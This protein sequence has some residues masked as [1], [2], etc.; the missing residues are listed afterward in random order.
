MRHRFVTFASAVLTLIVAG[1][2]RA[3][4]IVLVENA[5]SPPGPSIG[6]LNVDLLNTGP[7]TAIGSFSFALSVPSNSGITFTRVDTR[8]VYIFAFSGLGPDI[9]NP[10]PQAPGTAI[11]GSDF[12]TR[13]GG[14][15]IS[16]NETLALGRVLFTVSPSLQRGTVPVSLSPFPLTSLSDASVPIP[17]NIPITRLINGS[18]TVPEPPALVLAGIGTLGL[19]TCDWW[20]K[21]PGSMAVRSRRSETGEF[22]K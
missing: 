4:Y 13:P 15:I 12:T 3:D 18:I 5:S 22:T 9:T 2:G 21:R 8:T 17:N 14:E 6:S 10:T 1:P 7:D 20:R 11:A 19:L 16:H